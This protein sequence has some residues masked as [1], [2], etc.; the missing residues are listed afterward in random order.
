M[1]KLAQPLAPI[2]SE[3]ESFVYP[4]YVVGVLMLCYALSFIDRQVL[5]LLVEPIKEDLQLTDTKFSLLQGFAF[6]IF[7]TFVGLFMGKLAD[8]RNRRLIVAAGVTAW[9]VMTALCGMSKNFLHLFLA[10]VGVGVGESTLSPSAYSLIGDYFPKEKLGRAMST[11]TVGVYLGS[12]LAF[13]AGGLLIGSIP[14][15]SHL[16]LLGEFK[17]WQMIFLI[18]GISGLPLALLVLTIREPERGR[19]STDTPMDRESTEEVT[20]FNS[21]RYF[22]RNWR[23]YLPHFAGFSLLTMV[24]YGFHSWVPA[25]FIRHWGWQTADIGVMY[26]TINVLAAP[27]GVLCGG[28]CGD[29]LAKRGHGDAFIRGPII[30]AFCLLVPA[31]IATSPLMPSATLSLVVLTALHFFASFHGGMAVAALHTV[32]PIRMRAQATAC[33]LFF[34]N[35]IGLG[36]GPLVVALITDVVLKDTAAVGTSLM[37]VGAVTVP[38]A[39]A[40]LVYAGRKYRETVV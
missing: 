29:W 34:I 1:S 3:T 19:Y 6:A 18:L 7:Y 14:A 2:T 8:T 20:I 37:I 4:W 36:L 23:F 25:Y 32:T 11:Y 28:Y 38:G 13:L 15:V 21:V 33:Y 12:G 9:S 10:R 30:G 31:C 5:S 22:S 39:I 24:G 26:G 35:L 17:A 40:L 27:L 16:P